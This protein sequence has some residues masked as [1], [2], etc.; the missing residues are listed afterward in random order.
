M[1]FRFCRPDAGRI[2]NLKKQNAGP[3]SEKLL[4]L[5]QGLRNHRFSKGGVFMKQ[6]LTPEDVMEMGKMW[7]QPP[8]KAINQAG[9]DVLWLGMTAPKQEKWI[10][11]TECEV[12]RR[13]RSRFRFLCRHCQTLLSLVSETRS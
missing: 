7:R 9:P 4:R 5:P 8:D 13:Y 1:M 6:E 10:Y 11:Q 12:H 3:F 2:R